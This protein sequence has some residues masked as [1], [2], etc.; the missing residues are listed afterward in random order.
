V[1]SKT[2]ELCISCYEAAQYSDICPSNG[3]HDKKSFAAVGTTAGF[4][5]K[6]A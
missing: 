3:E 5:S 2:I 6:A 4:L 1:K